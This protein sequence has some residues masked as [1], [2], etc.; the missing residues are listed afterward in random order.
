ME[1]LV[2]L[3]SY[4]LA[5]TLTMHIVSQRHRKMTS[6]NLDMASENLPSL[7]SSYK[8]TLLMAI[9]IAL[10]FAFYNVIV[11][12][13]SVTISGDRQNYTLNF[14][15]LRSSSSDGL[16]FLIGLLRKVSSNVES[17]YYVSTFVPMLI[18]MLAYRESDDA[19]P[20]ALFFLLTT[21]YVFFTFAG[22][23]QCYT[24]A[25]AALCIVLALRNKGIKD[26]IFSIISIALAIWFHP[27]GYML[28]PLYIMIRVKKSRWINV[29]FFLFLIII[30]FFFEPL[31]LRVARIASSYAPIVAVKIYAY[32]GDTANEALETAGSMSALK[33]I[34]F[35]I[36]ALVGWIKRKELH[37]VVHN[38]DNY[39]FLSGVIS[40]IYLASVYNA[41]VIRL[42]YFLVLPVGIFF[43][44]LMQH[45]SR[46]NNYTIINASVLGLNA[47]LTLRFVVLIYLN[48]GGF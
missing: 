29:V 31:L 1:L 47:L 3:L 4:F 21:Q 17:L 44:Q 46:K 41:W 11:T 30:A 27:T 48:Y 25:F 28:I 23:K 33:G 22:M 20:K 6:I 15:G 14:F 42:A 34:P 45:M 8:M 18:T 2:S 26:T 16:M 9:T 19:S 24:N 43:A 7:S 38:Y 39:L 32:F 12:K 10:L 37:T 40:V 13:M 5:V 35:Y 36:I